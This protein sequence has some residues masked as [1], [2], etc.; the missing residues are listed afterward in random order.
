ML[1]RKRSFTA[2]SFIPLASSVVHLLR[3]WYRESEWR[4][5]TLRG[6]FSR[7]SVQVYLAIVASSLVGVVVPI[8]L[9]TFVLTVLSEAWYISAGNMVPSSSARAVPA[10]SYVTYGGGVAL[11]SESR[12]AFL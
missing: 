11:E 8:F 12:C 5:S 3:T 9:V 6:V 10:D 2:M 7:I 4:Y 1:W